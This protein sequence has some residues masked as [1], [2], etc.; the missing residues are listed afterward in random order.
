MGVFHTICNLLSI[1]GKRFQDAG[2]RDLCVK[3]GVLAE[4]S[5]GGLMAG[6]KYNRAIRVHKLVYEALMM[7]VWK[8]FITWLEEHHAEEV[9]S[10][11]ESIN[12]IDI[13]HS[14]V[15]QGSLQDFLQQQSCRRILQLFQEYLKALKDKHSLSDSWMSYIDIVEIMLG[16]LRA[17]RESDWMFHLAS[18]RDMIPWCFACDTLNYARFLSYYYATMSRL[19]IEHPEIHNHFMQGGFSVQIGSHNP[20]GCIPV[21]QTIEETINKDTQTPGGTKVFS[22]KPG[23]V[24]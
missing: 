10:L 15:S 17:S 1:I 18:I 22:L 3:S 21:D 2:L 16:L 24:A 6:R 14:N 23:A 4:G 19:P 13:F 8:G 20:F 9:P 12:N 7:L 11:K 5:V